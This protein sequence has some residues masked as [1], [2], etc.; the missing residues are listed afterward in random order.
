MAQINITSEKLQMTMGVVSLLTTVCAVFLYWLH[1][2]LTTFAQIQDVRAVKVQLMQQFNE[3]M[4][5]QTEQNLRLYE[6]DKANG[7][8][9]TPSDVREY[10]QLKELK[11][12]LITNKTVMIETSKK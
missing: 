9:L 7:Y 2:H 5:I 1:W 12:R 11:K 3:L 8:T 6:R 4:I 10:E